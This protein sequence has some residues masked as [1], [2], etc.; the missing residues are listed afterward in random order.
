[1]LVSC[2][3]PNKTD[4]RAH[5]AIQFVVDFDSVTITVKCS[6][7]LEMKLSVVVLV[8]A[9]IFFA[10]AIAAPTNEPL[11]EVSDKSEVSTDIS[12]SLIDASEDID[13]VNR[14][15]KSSG[16]PKTICFEV[17]DHQG[18]S[19]LQ[20]SDALDSE[21]AGTSLYPSFSPVQSYGSSP[22]YA[23]APSYAPQPSYSAPA[24]PSYKVS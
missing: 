4:P 9:G 6:S 5:E 7:N 21:S 17:N 10:Q 8:V 3:F 18:S 14:S 19:Y 22:S 13:D 1:M 20:C 12:S 15:K 24:A 2:N 23:P 16:Q 11:S